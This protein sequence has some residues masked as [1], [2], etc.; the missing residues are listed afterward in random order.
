MAEKSVSGSERTASLL[1][2]N[3][4]CTLVDPVRDLRRMGSDDGDSLALQRERGFIAGRPF[5][6]PE[7]K[8]KLPAAPR[9]DGRTTLDVM[10]VPDTATP[11]PRTGGTSRFCAPTAEAQRIGRRACT[12]YQRT[13]RGVGAGRLRERH[14]VI[15]GRR[16][17]R[18]IPQCCGRFA[19]RRITPYA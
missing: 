3:D 4:P 12:R 8:A 16:H 1:R 11:Y 7:R 2:L 15:S 17:L 6:A 14:R 19:E 5:E 13:G 9:D 18:D 10:Q